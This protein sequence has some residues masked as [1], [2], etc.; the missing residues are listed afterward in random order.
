M[1][2]N[3]KKYTKIY[4][5]NYKIFTIRPKSGDF[6]PFFTSFVGEEVHFGT[7]IDI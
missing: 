1:L 7:I 5:K 2:L 4:L 6:A 3:V